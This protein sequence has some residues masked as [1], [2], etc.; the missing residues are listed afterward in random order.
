MNHLILQWEDPFKHIKWIIVQEAPISFHLVQNLASSNTGVWIADTYVWSDE[1]C[2]RQ[3]LTSVK[4]TYL[5]RIFAGQTSKWTSK[6]NSANILKI[7]SLKIMRKKI[8]ELLN[9]TLYLAISSCSLKRHRTK[10]LTQ[11]QHTT[12]GLHSPIHIYH[13]YIYKVS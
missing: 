5:L 3:Y 4:G 7:M 10:F 9:R 2:L 11:V 6:N 1:S 8:E 13:T 12:V